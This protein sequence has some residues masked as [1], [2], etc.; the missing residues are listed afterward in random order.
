MSG[1]YKYNL[2]KSFSDKNKRNNNNGNSTS[3]DNNNINNKNDCEMT[4]SLKISSKQV[5]PKIFIKTGY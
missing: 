4:H 5:L 3:S 1:F 2:A